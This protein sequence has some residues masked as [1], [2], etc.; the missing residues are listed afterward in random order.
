MSH[1]NFTNW[2]LDTRIQTDRLLVLDTKQREESLYYG[3]GYVSGNID[4][5]GPMNQL[6][7]E[8]NV[9]TSEGTIF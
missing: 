2:S 9:S 7:V 4:V 1:V 8:A 6:F 3:T 5:S